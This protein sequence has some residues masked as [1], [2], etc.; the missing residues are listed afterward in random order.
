MAQ[1]L[2]KRGLLLGVACA[3]ALAGAAATPAAATPAGKNGPIAFRRYLGPDRTRGSIFTIWADGTHERQ[4]T[5][6][7]ADSS[8]DYPDFASDGSFIALQRCTPASCRS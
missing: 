1:H 5:L 3:L 8:D 4:V 7:P 2:L 6:P